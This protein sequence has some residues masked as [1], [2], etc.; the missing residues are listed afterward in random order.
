MLIIL[1]NII[2]DLY[3]AWHEVTGKNRPDHNAYIEACHKSLKEDCI[4]QHDFQ[5]YQEADLVISKFFHVYNWNRPHS[6]LKYMTLKEFYAMI[7][8]ANNWMGSIRQFLD[9]LPSVEGYTLFA[10]TVQR[11]NVIG[12]SCLMSI[13]Q[14]F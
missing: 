5:T 3:W 6:S 7:N 8:A 2:C 9:K 10:T 11:I 1:H 14:Y 4:W 12:S 13:S